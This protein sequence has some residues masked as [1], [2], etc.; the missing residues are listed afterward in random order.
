MA[1]LV[2]RP[3][4]GNRTGAH[5]FREKADDDLRQASGWL[6]RVGERPRNCQGAFVDSTGL[7]GLLAVMLA[8]SECFPGGSV[9]VRACVPWVGAGDDRVAPL[10]FFAALLPC[11]LSSVLWRMVSRMASPTCPQAYRG[12]VTAATGSGHGCFIWPG[13][14]R[15]VMRAG[16]IPRRAGRAWG[17]P[18]NSFMPFQGLMRSCCAVQFISSQ[19][20]RRCAIR[21]WHIYL[22][23]CSFPAQLR[24]SALPGRCIL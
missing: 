21:V 18:K 19:F 16:S 6:R 10:R 7:A 1:L 14:R 3:H 9:M 5:P 20:P 17:I 23:P 13:G 4:K 15:T 22:R 12:Q 24:F 8:M 11:L 2:H